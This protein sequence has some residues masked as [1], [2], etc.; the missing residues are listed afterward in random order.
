MVQHKVDYLTTTQE[1]ILAVIRRRILEDGEAPTIAELRAET[2]R[3]T[4]GV[5]YQLRELEAKCAIVREPGQP[6][7]IRLA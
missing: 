6:R 4:G 2:G 7:G 3:S 1:T 5:V